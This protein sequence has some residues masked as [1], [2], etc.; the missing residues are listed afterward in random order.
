MRK[1]IVI[2]GE[3]KNREGFATPKNKKGECNVLL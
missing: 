1:V 3:Y 2:N